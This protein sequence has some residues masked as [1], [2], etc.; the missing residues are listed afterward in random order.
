MDPWREVR[1]PDKNFGAARI[2]GVSV[3]PLARRLAGER[4]IDLSRI[5]GSGPRGPQRAGAPPNGG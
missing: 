4:G 2:G 5:S 3:T 1:T